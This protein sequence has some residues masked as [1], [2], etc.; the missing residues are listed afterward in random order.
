MELFLPQMEH[1]YKTRTVVAIVLLRAWKGHLE[2]SF[3]C[4][5]AIHHR[6]R[7]TMCCARLAMCES[8]PTL[9]TKH[10]VVLVIEA[11]E[12]FLTLR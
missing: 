11:S 4:E 2:R 9:S 7:A 6:R 10:C 12:H 8:A 1:A 5:C 3:I